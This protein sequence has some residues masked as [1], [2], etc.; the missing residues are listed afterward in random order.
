M[1]QLV[2]RIVWDDEVESSSL[3]AP[4]DTMKT[5]PYCGILQPDENF[6]IAVVSNGKQYRRRKCK[7]CKRQT[8]VH[9]QTK[10][11]EWLEGYKATLHCETCGCSDYRVLE[12]HHS[13]PNGKDFNIGDMVQMGLSVERIKKEISKCQVLCANCHRIEHYK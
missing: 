7:A 1:A 2:A 4:T 10:I 13:G 6:E 11:R 5:C 9:R 12:F 8:R 3:S